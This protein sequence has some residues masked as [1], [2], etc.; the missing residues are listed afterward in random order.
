MYALLCALFEAFLYSRVSKKQEH[1]PKKTKS[2]QL[3]MALVIMWPLLYCLIMKLKNIYGT[4][5]AQ[6]LFKL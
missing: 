3:D 1:W 2:G 5:K 4:F 6:K